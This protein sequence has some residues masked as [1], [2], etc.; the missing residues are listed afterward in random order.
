MSRKLFLFIALLACLALPLVAAAQDAAPT[1]DPYD[2]QVVW[3]TL[4]VVHEA[5]PNNTAATATAA[6]INTVIDGEVGGSDVDYFKFTGMAGDKIAF[7]GDMHWVPV[8]LLKPNQTTLPLTELALVSNVYTVVWATLPSDGVYTVRLDE[9]TDYYDITIVQLTGGEPNNNTPQ[10]AIPAT[11]GQTLALAGN[12]PCDVDWYSFQ[13]RAGDVFLWPYSQFVRDAAGNALPDSA[14]GV[15]L[16]RDGVYYLEF[17]D[18]TYNAWDD[19]YDC[20]SDIWPPQETL[21]QSLWV[22]AA[23]AGLGGNAALKPG[24]IATRQTAAGQWQ[25]VFDASDVGIT[26]NVDAI[27]RLPNGDQLLSLAAAQTVAGLGQVAPQDIIRFTP[28]SLGEN[29]AGSF[30]WFLDGSDVGLTTA[31]ENIDAISMQANVDHPLRVSLSG[32]GSV[33]QQTGGNV[34]VADEDIITLVDTQLGATSAGK[35]RMTV[36]GSTIAGMGAE[37]I[38]G[39]AWIDENLPALN[40][41]L[42]FDSAFKIQGVKGGPTSVFQIGH[43]LWVKNLTDVK[44]DGLAVGPAMP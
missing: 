23:V 12:Y 28:T 1:T 40:S 36:D 16:P 2:W 39:I 32:A 20:D 31:G 21:G 5:E 27:E 10:T 24:D 34:A 29:T 18:Y 14:R 30:A 42:S 41:L 8:T 7:A 15:V 9:P 22:S 4:P 3:P 33:P 43:G 37:D 11:I 19:S 44:I 26:A 6:A 38:S 35:W 17:Q 13:G 25:L